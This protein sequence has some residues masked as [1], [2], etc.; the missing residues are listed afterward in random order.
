MT[1]QDPTL[2]GHQRVVNLKG[3]AT[4]GPMTVRATARTRTNFA[5][6]H[7]LAA[8]RFSRLVGQIEGENKDQP[9]G[10]FWEEVL[11]FSIGCVVC[12]VAAIEAYANEIFADREKSFPAR[13]PEL[14]EKLWEKFEQ[15]STIDKFDLALFLLNR[16]KLE[17]GSQ[18]I[19]NLDGLIRLRNALTHFK[20]E[21]DDERIEHAKVSD[22]LKG[23]FAPSQ[24]FGPNEPLFPRAWA[25]HGCTRWAVETCLSFARIF[26]ASADFPSKFEKFSDRLKTE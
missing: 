21:W 4:L 26:E 25:T 2:Q 13:D 22:R 12:A 17:K 16:P 3:T 14:V 15:S 5:V 1:E 9:F 11:A 10:P 7:L 19:Q 23:R 8:A 24:L 18:P 20:P 6:Q